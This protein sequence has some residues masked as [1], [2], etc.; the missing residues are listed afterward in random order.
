MLFPCL[1]T[2]PNASYYTGEFYFTG[3]VSGVIFYH[4]TIVT[5]SKPHVTATT[6]NH[7]RIHIRPAYTYLRKARLGQGYPTSKGSRR[8]CHSHRIP[9]RTIGRNQMSMCGIVDGEELVPG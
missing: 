2:M 3:I 7:D 9:Q 6:Q 8:R 1:S 4:T 5:S